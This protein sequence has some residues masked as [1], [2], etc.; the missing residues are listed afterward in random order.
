MSPLDPVACAVVLIAAFVLAGAAQ[1]AWFAW[2]GSQRLAFPLDGGR[3]WRGRRI[4]GDNK[5]VRGLIVII[6]AATV[7]LPA[8][9]WL[10]SQLSPATGAIWPLSPLRYA[11]LGAWCAAGFMLGELPNS[12]LKRRAGVL[13]GA[14]PAGRWQLC[15]LVVDRLDSPL[16]LLAAAA[17]VVDVPADTWLIVLAVGP[18]F[19][20]C[21]SALMFTLGL[22]PRLA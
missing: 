10:A 9:A 8:V 22:K 1:T 6:P 7:A 2:P 5:T 4:L 16:G 13:P 12:F 20:W 14:A 21:F 3:H 19:H 15:Q 18:L 17:L 11:A